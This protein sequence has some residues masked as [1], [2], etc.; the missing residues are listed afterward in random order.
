MKIIIIFI[1]ILIAVSLY[2]K[3]SLNGKKI[4][5][6]LVD[7]HSE[8]IYPATISIKN[9]KIVKIERNNKKYDNFIVPGL[10]DSHIHIESSMMTPSNFGKI[11]VTHGTVATVSDSHEIA[12]VLGLEGVNW[13]IEDGKKVLFKFN[14]GA[15]PCVPATSFETSGAVLGAKEIEEL[16]KR[17][18]IKYMA[19]MMNYPGVIFGDKDVWKKIA[20]AKKYNKPIDG[21][22]P[23][24]QGADLEEYVKAGISTDHETTNLAEAKEKIGLGMKIQI[25]EG[26]AAKDFENLKTLI[27]TNP[28][29][30]MF[31]SDDK[32]PDDLVK[33]HINELVKR[34][35]NL[36]YD[37]FDV[38]KVASLN[39]VKHY[40]LDVGLLREG[41][42]ADFI[43]V[44]NFEDFNILK[45]YIDG[46]LVAENGKSLIKTSKADTPNN[47]NTSKKSLEDIQLKADGKK[48]NVINAI[49]GQLIT[50]SSVEKTKIENGYVVS[51]VEN[52]ILKIVVVNRYEN[53][54]VSIGFI[55]NIGL[56]KGAI[57]T[58]VAHDSHNVIAVGVSDKDI[59][60]ALNLV[61]ENRGGMSLAYEDKEEFL[62]LPI[63]GLMSDKNIDY[64]A[65]KYSDLTQ[66]SK[67]EMG[68]TLRAPYMTLSFMALLVIP[69]IKLGDKGLF[70]AKAFKFMDIFEK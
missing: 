35:L 43:V 2:V 68:S 21:H 64:V 63:A 17:D 8:K 52:D 36:G 22:A 50:M 12:N 20:V 62:A 24:V 41:D 61:I 58:S 47:F 4:S 67:Q 27:Q 53:A 6:N 11:A 39:P 32:H 69:E 26:S 46:K 57:A 23:Y 60:K 31:C 10:I 13:M 30:V 19:E 38:L 55:K 70:D 65:N 14:F 42:F 49:D 1:V 44:D 18:D 54:P 16:M 34:A 3:F 37:K 48:I 66:I 25:R 29:M 5:G 28:D 56:K 33:S 45:T 59:L 9:N 15:S 40:N 51:D 7:L